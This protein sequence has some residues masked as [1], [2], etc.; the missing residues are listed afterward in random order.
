[1]ISIAALLAIAIHFFVVSAKNPRE[2]FGASRKNINLSLDGN[3][4]EI[5]TE[6]QTVRDVLAEQNISAQ[7]KVVTL[8]DLDSRIYQGSQVA[9]FRIKKVTVKEEER[10]LNWKQHRKLWKMLFGRMRILIFWRMT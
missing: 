8:P 6:A 9:V 4:F 1:M 10:R 5:E 2:D 7:D 3:T